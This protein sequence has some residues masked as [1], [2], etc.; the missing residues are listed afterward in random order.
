MTH[1]LEK[2]AKQGKIN[3]DASIRDKQSIVI[4]ASLEKCFE[5]LT[6]IKNWP[7]WN[8]EIK[9]KEFE[10]FDV[11]SKFSWKIHGFSIHSVIQ[12]IE[13]P[14]QVTWTGK[15]LWIKAIH[16]WRFEKVEKNQ[17]IVI[18]EES[19]QGFLLPLFYTHQKLHSDLLNWLSRLKIQVESIK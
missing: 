2:L 13:R 19:M 14:Y 15:A 8:Q 7:E 5:T 9:I 18:S 4:N 17:T 3:T 11:G 16:N 1:K 10:E 6:N 12:Q